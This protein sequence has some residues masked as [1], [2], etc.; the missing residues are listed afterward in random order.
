V[1]TIKLKNQTKYVAKPSPG[2][3]RPHT[4]ILGQRINDSMFAIEPE[5]KEEGSIELPANG[6][7]S[8]QAMN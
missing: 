3:V 8:V 6:N 4:Q 7:M 1:I 5:L 2:S